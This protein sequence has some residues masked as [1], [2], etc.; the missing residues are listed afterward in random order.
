MYSYILGKNKI[1][2][3]SSLRILNLSQNRIASEGAKILASALK[4]NKSLV[5]LDLS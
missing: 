4:K 5:F 1:A 2:P 3:C